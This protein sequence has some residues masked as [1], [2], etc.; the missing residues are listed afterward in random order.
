M[1]WKNLGKAFGGISQGENCQQD[2]VNLGML[3]QRRNKELVGFWYW[4]LKKV[5]LSFKR[6]GN[7]VALDEQK[8]RCGKNG[9]VA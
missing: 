8:D 4:E 6:R 1:V 9:G 2:E 5:H 3:A 7:A